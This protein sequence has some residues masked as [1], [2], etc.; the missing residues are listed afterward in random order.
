M[1]THWAVP[2]GKW[3]LAPVLTLAIAIA[4]L[5]T[6]LSGE[7]SAGRVVGKDGVIH[8]CYKAGGKHKGA[9]RLVAKGMHCRRTER[10]LKWSVRG[11]AG[12]G[13]DNGAAGANGQAGATGA[14]GE[15]G[16]AGLEAKVTEL[17]TR[18]ETL[19]TTLQGVTNGALQEAIGA[20]ADVN[21][22]CTQATAL[23]DQVDDLGT[24]VAGISL[25]TLLAVVLDIPPLPTALPPFSCP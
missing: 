17:T 24:A 15:A 5:L 9:V 16:K 22:L 11:P 3:K 23:T 1:D 10:K 12:A 19:E 2:Q 25:N 6:G 18:V 8:A 7:A 13:G 20:V 4:A 21:A 14:A